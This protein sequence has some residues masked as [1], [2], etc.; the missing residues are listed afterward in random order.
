MKENHNLTKET[1]IS[2]YIDGHQP[3]HIRELIVNLVF[4][5]SKV[6]INII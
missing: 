5:Y 2:I 4:P 6:K 3:T 1:N